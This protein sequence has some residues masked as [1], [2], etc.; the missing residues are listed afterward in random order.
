MK[1]AKIVKI[2]EAADN[3]RE[4]WPWCYRLSCGHYFYGNKAQWVRGGVIHQQKM[5]CNL[6]SVGYSTEH[7]KTEEQHASDACFHALRPITD[8][9]PKA[10]TA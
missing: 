9:L 10:V 6:C 3:H 2:L 1:T 5:R 4:S 8:W 7:F